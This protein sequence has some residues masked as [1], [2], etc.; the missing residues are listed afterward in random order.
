MEISVDGQEI[1]EAGWYDAGNL[2]ELPGETS[3]ARKIIDWFV[4]TQF[5]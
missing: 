1:T 5:S 2:P 4:R 3:I